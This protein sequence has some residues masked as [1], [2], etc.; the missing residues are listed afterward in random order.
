MPATATPPLP[1]DKSGERVRRMF[2]QIAGRYDLLNHLLSL[3]IDK[4]WRRKTVRLV[5]PAPGMRVLDVCTGTGDLALAYHAAG[6]GQVEVVGT[7]F[8]HEM[9][10]IARQKTAGRNPQ[11][12]ATGGRAEARHGSPETTNASP[13]H[14]ALGAALR[15]VPSHP[16]LRLAGPRLAMRTETPLSSR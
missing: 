2:G 15:S 7:D 14:N 8:C 9:L 13:Q 11:K 3:N 5:P 10:E 12:A 1:V 6:Q 16:G 4:R